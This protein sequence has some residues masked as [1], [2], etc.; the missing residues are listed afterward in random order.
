MKDNPRVIVLNRWAR[1]RHICFK[2]VRPPNGHIEFFTVLPDIAAHAALDCITQS[3]PSGDQF[4]ASRTATQRP[5]YGM[6]DSLGRVA[7]RPNR[8]SVRRRHFAFDTPELSL[9]AAWLRL[10]RLF[11]W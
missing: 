7:G 10:G 6:V 4:P 1:R 5:E 9:K 11:F 8:S 3:S 2:V